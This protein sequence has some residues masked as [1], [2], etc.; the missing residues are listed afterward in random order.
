MNIQRLTAFLII[1]LALLFMS[2]QADPIPVA[3]YSFEFPVIDPNANLQLAIPLAAMWTELDND[4]QASY[5]TGVFRN[6]SAGNADHITNPDG[7]Q[8][9]FLGGEVGNSMMQFIEAT[10]QAGKSYELT[11]SIC[12]SH[13]APPS[14]DD[15]LELAFLY[16]DVFTPATIATL[17]VSSAGLTSTLLDDF[18]LT[19][20][21][22][23][24]SDTWA[25]KNIGIAIRATGDGGGYWDLDN[26]RMME[27]RGTPDFTGDSVVNLPDFAKMAADWLSC[28]QVTTDVTG[29][30]CVNEADLQILAEYWL[31]DV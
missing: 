7:E 10:Y 19:L 13:T 28:S 27:F 2:A 9:A 6:K 3:N 20:P 15:P 22:V 14:E 31:D 16:W 12:V 21:T 4:T 29:D 30:G 5:N 26:V 8:L 17:Q 11:V 25:G 18:K 23:Q 24:N 1:S